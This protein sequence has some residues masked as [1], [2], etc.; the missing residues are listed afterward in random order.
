LRHGRGLRKLGRTGAHRLRLLQHITEGLFRSF[1]I[2]TTL[3]KAK[4]VRPFAEHLIT[5]ARRGNPQSQ[6]LA[7]RV[8]HD[9][10]AYTTLFTK[11]GPHFADRAGG[12]TRILR[13]GRRPGDG[14]EVV[15]LELVGRE[16]LGDAPGKAPSKARKAAKEKEGAGAGRK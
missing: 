3:E 9:K 12:Y 5:L 1:Q 15:V 2:Q 11:L 10:M 14:A 13:V 16:Q 4:E 6:R 8:L 7:R